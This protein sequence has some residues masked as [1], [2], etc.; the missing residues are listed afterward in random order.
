[1]QT[2]KCPHCATEIEITEALSHQLEEQIRT[3]VEKEHQT[4]LAN[5]LKAVEKKA[6]AKAAKES[7]LQLK[8]LQ[9]EAKEEKERNQKFVEQITASTKKIREMERKEEERELEMQ[10]K[11]AIE[12]DKIRQ[13]EKKKA[14]EEHN[15]VLKEK[16]K[17]LEDARKQIE[18]MKRKID[19][20]S[21]QTQGEVLELELE[22]L[23]AETFPFDTIDEVKKGTKG[24]D[25]QQTVKS[26][27]GTSCGIMLWEMKN[28]Q[29]KW[30]DKWIEKL[31]GDQR[32]CGAVIAILVS[33]TLP[34]GMSSDMGFMGGVWICKPNLILPLA[35]ALRERLYEVAKQKAISQNRGDK[36]D[37]LYDYVTGVEFKQ[38]IEAL[39]EVYSDM[40]DQIDKERRSFESQWKAREKQLE[41][42]FRSTASIFGSMQGIAGQSSLPT[43]KGLDMFELESGE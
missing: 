27:Q 38:Q 34:K 10:K 32:A 16:E 28:Y 33:S 4:E 3:S 14:D 29:D 31:K 24:A 15:L 25:I 26:R 35:M 12:S 1:M 13:E 39:V 30:S 19:Q 42:F 9:E 40:R 23:L 36:S 8:A 20:G 37:Q 21:Q 6:L 2:I 17:K 22:T 11:M 5:Q 41:R 18:E 7:E 43:L